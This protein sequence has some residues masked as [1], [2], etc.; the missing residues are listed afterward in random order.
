MNSCRAQRSFSDLLCFEEMSSKNT[1]PLILETTSDSV[2]SMRSKGYRF[3]GACI[4]HAH[5]HRCI[6]DTEAP[7]V[8][9]T[10]GIEGINIW[11]PPGQEWQ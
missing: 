3:L 11:E 1:V 10:G 5:Y 9:A 4:D 2:E 8:V 6:W 7:W